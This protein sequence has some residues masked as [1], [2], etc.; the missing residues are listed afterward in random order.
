VNERRLIV[1]T[2]GK[3]ASIAAKTSHHFGV[4]VMAAF[5]APHVDAMETM[6]YGKTP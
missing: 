5:S 1:R 2:L 6:I 3:S 4:N